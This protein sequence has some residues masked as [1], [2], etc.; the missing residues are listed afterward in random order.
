MLLAKAILLQYD[1]IQLILGHL[2]SSIIESQWDQKFDQGWQ[3][4]PIY[5][6]PH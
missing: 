5:Q 4:L 3:R 2:A 1:E 6:L